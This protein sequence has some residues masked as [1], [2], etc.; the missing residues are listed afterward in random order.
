[1]MALFRFGSTV[2]FVVE[3]WWC[4][5]G[6]WGDQRSI[7]GAEQIRSISSSINCSFGFIT[8]ASRHSGSVFQFSDKWHISKT[9]HLYFYPHTIINTFQMKKI[10][11]WMW[12]CNMHVIIIKQTHVFYHCI[13]I[14]S[15]HVHEANY[16]YK[17]IIKKLI[18]LNFS[19][20]SFRDCQHREMESISN[21]MAIIIGMY[22]FYEG[23][24]RKLIGHRRV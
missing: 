17:W 13:N 6:C 20:V 14:D 22:S 19:C 18:V 12:R 11:F 15:I 24:F 9:K 16:I 8:N 3:S 10:Q 4:R 21:V 23:A 5:D 1:M 7:A 2:R